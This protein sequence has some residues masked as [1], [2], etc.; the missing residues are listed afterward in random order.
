MNKTNNYASKIGSK[1]RAIIAIF[2][3]I[4]LIAGSVT[5]G[6]FIGITAQKNKGVETKNDVQASDGLQIGILEQKQMILSTA[7][8]V[9]ESGELQKT[10]TAIITPEDA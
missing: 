8:T 4:L 5:A 9:S 7:T 10:I 1:G 2:V 3:V 6:A